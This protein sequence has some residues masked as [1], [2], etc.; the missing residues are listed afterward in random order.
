MDAK[1]VEGNLAQFKN[2]LK[3]FIIFGKFTKKTRKNSRSILKIFEKNSDTLHV[4][5]I[6]IYIHVDIGLYVFI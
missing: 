1:M 6:T 3:K 2:A 4:Y 5:N